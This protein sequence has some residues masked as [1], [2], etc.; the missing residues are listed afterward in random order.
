MEGWH[1]D[2]FWKWVHSLSRRG[3]WLQFLTGK[4]VTLLSFVVTLCFKS[5]LHYELVISV[6][7]SKPY[8][9]VFVASIIDPEPCLDMNLVL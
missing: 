4:N 8:I 7:I 6:K 5:V 2:L 1:G 3:S 9:K